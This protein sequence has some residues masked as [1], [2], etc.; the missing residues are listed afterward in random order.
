MRQTSRWWILTVLIGL[1]VCLAACE[2]Q[3]QN[4]SEA[5][6]AEETSLRTV[7]LQ[8]SEAASKRGADEFVR[9][10]ADGAIFLPPNLPAMTSRDAIQRW[11]SQLMSNPGFSVSWQPTKVGV[12]R[13]GDLG[14]TSGIYE[15]NLTGANGKAVSDH[16]KYLTVWKKQADGSWRVVADTFNSDLPAPGAASH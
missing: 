16:G 10:F 9:Y 5:R 14:Y 12:S 4:P 3:P 2:Q 6:A 13:E 11:A 8:W 7:D 1:M 15:L